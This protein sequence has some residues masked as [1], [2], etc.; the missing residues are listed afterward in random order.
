MEDNNL[1]NYF[2]EEFAGHSESPPPSVWS[3]IEASLSS[4][5]PIWYRKYFWLLLL[6]F[7]IGGA[8]ILGY[9]IYEMNGRVA[10]LENQLD[11]EKNLDKST[12]GK[13]NDQNER[14]N[15]ESN[16]SSPTNTEDAQIWITKDENLHVTISDQSM[17]QVTSNKKELSTG[18]DE[19]INASA[20]N[21]RT[22][23]AESLNSS[24]EE[25][26]W[27][28]ASVESESTIGSELESEGFSKSSRNSTEILVFKNPKELSKTNTFYFDELT[29]KTIQPNYLHPDF[30]NETRKV[31]Y[32]EGSRKQW[33]LFVYGMA[34]YTHRRV[35]VENDAIPNVVNELNDV[36]NSLIRPGA[37]LMIFR[38]LH[39]SFRVGMGIEFNEWVQQANYPIEVGVEEITEELISF[40][41]GTSELE[42]NGSLP[43]SIADA[44][45]S[46]DLLESSFAIS[47][48]NSTLSPEISPLVFDVSSRR[49]TSYLTIPLT[50][51]YVRDYRA[52]R[53]ML[54]GGISLHRILNSQV[55]YSVSPDTNGIIFQESDP[56]EGTYF[57]FQFGMAAEYMLNENFSLR[58]NPLYRGWMSPV[59]ENEQFRTL[60]FGVGIRGGLVMRLNP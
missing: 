44:N 19:D 32:Y 34:N 24:P 28:S 8:A 15:S 14:K 11:E 33:N 20:A 36:E 42:V 43:S 18:K 13:E 55:S 48:E 56:V 31:D 49:K 16:S 27:V 39:R 6:L 58:V 38:D 1:D 41:S 10:S 5:T 17:G 35:L 45:F 47:E 9:T 25:E 57:A 22:K 23:R 52:F 46:V 2:K 12:S 50:L 4:T 37:G 60:P 29:P 53:V 59:F 3:D 21:S 54:N 30:R 26:I 40:S 51:E 7:I